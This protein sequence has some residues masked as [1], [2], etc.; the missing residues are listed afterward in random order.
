[1]SSYS[2]LHA[3]FDASLQALPQIEGAVAKSAES[4]A[5]AFSESLA[6]LDFGALFA[7]VIQ[8]DQLTTLFGQPVETS[9]QAE[10]AVFIIVQLYRL[11]DERGEFVNSDLFA[12][13]LPENLQQQPPSH[14]VRI[15]DRVANLFALVNLPDH[16][17]DGFIRA[18]FRVS[19]ASPDKQLNQAPA[20]RLVT[21]SRPITV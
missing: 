12:L 13:L 3:S 18:R 10:D 8:H 5:Q 21:F 9:T 16:A 7:V 11:R 4:D 14:A 19:T 20:Q 6:T 1:V 2:S 17:I 15:T